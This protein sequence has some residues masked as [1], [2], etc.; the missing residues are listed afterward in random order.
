MVNVALKIA[1]FRSS[2]KLPEAIKKRGSHGHCGHSLGHKSHVISQWVI[3]F[4]H[5]YMGIVHDFKKKQVG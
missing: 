5:V 4:K 1:M 3:R 2:V